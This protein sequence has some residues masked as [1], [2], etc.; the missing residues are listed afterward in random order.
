MQAMTPR[1]HLGE[2]TLLSYA[3]GALPVALAIVAAT[4]LSLC[5]SCRRQLRL[6]ER[7]GG[8]LMALQTGAP[9]PAGAREAMLARL[10]EPLRT[11]AADAHEALPIDDPHALPVPLHP[12]FGRA[13][14]AL[15]WRWMAP[16]MHYIRARVDRGTLLLIRI[17][18]GKGL[19]RHGHHGDELT[20]VLQGA[21]DDEFG[22]F[23][24]GDLAEL[25]SE[26]RHKP[27]SA[28]GVPCIC[29]GGLIGGLRYESW[30][31]RALQRL[32]GI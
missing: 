23:R 31:A 24:H 10:D 9:S 6:A 2:A 25:G 21:Y 7:I 28:A 29:V 27:V 22:H 12:Y 16:G 20:C 3:A 5:A 19:P 18:P 26:E 13:F 30:F 1:H 32:L 17:A 11:H 4:H 14:D 8:G 15:R